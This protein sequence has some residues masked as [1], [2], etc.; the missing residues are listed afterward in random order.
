[1]SKQYGNYSILIQWDPY[2]RIHVVTVPELPGCM[3]HGKSYEEAVQQAEEAIELWIE[4]NEAWERPV[5]PPHVL[6]SSPIGIEQVR[7]AA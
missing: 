7:G 6:T 3:T 1:M 5:P 2:D 4:A